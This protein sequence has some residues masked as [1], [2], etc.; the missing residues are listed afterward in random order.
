MK[1]AG[2]ARI[3]MTGAGF[4]IGLFPVFILMW[5]QVGEGTTENVIGTGTHGTTNEYLTIKFN[6]TGEAGKRIGIGKNSKLGASRAINLAHNARDRNSD[7]KDNSNINRGL[8][9]RNNSN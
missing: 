3:I 7:N 8:R 5:I 2:I 1:A 6:R 9:F 4:I